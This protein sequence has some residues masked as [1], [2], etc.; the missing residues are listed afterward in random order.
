[1]IYRYGI[2]PSQGVWF[3][4]EQEGLPRRLSGGGISRRQF[5]KLGAAAAAA[6]LVALPVPTGTDR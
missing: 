3:K 5:A 6:A 4:R 1:M 2:L